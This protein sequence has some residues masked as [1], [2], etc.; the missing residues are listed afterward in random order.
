[1]KTSFGLGIGNSSK[2]PSH[3]RQNP[4]LLGMVIQLSFPFLSF[5]GSRSD[6]VCLSKFPKYPLTPAESCP[7]KPSA[8]GLET[9]HGRMV[10]SYCILFREPLLYS[11]EVFQPL[12]FSLEQL[13]QKRRRE[14][15]SLFLMKSAA[16][17]A[18]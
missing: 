8:L 10:I 6:T 3:F 2:T 11:V 5:S 9:T 1:M 14:P 12:A 7:P 18:L 16:L 4:W 15:N 17:L 13:G